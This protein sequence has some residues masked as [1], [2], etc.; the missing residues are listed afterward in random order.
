MTHDFLEYGVRYLTALMVL[1]A[2]ACGDI[3]KTP[4]EPDEPV[5]ERTDADKH[6][7]DRLEVCHLC[8]LFDGS[9]CDERHIYVDQ[10]GFAIKR[11]VREADID[12]TYNA[13][14]DGTNKV[15]P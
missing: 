2:G 6:N 7:A 13:V 15:R 9:V 4:S 14:C 12:E 11:V 8:N 1:V 5:D 10:V 3:D